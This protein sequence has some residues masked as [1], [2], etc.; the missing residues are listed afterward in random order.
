MRNLFPPII[1]QIDERGK[2][3]AKQKDGR[4]RAKITVGTDASGKSIVKYVS[5]R[6]KKELEAA[7]AAAREKYI[8][9]ANAAPEGVLFERYALTWYEVYKQPH[10]GVSAQMSYRTAL[11]KH[12]FPALRAR[13][14]N[15]QGI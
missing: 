8:T 4:Y 5:G 7:K 1:K 6:T 2:R 10:I 3:M 14:G 13:G 11:Y 9:G 15:L 12:I